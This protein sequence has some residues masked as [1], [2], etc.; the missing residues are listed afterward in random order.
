MP[1]ATGVAGL[2]VIESNLDDRARGG[3]CDG[4]YSPAPMGLLRG[5]GRGVSMMTSRMRKLRVMES[6]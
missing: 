5:R 3:G 2:R 1:L 4:D 6:K